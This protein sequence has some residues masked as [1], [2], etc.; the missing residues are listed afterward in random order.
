VGK[1]RIKVM[2]CGFGRRGGV[3]VFEKRRKILFL[4][5]AIFFLNSLAKPAYSWGFWGHR[6][7]NNNAVFLLPPPLFGFY[8]QH[9][10]YL[11]AHAADADMR[12][13][14]IKE[15]APRHYIDLDQYQ[16]TGSAKI[17]VQWKD[18]VNQYS[19]D[20][21]QLH[22]IVPWWIMVMHE[23]LK[24]AFAEKDVEQILKLSADIGHYIADAHVPLHASSNHNGQ[25]TDQLGIHAFWE[26]RLP[27]LFAEKQYDLFIG[28]AAYLK[29]P[30]HFIWDRVYESGA[31]AD[32]VL[33]IEKELSRQSA[34]HEKMSFEYRNDRLVRQYSEKYAARYHKQLNGMVERRMRSSVYAVASFWYTAW[35]DAGQPNLP[36]NTPSN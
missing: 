12:R 28:R 26:S 6:F 18:A 4:S 32:T 16:K 5:C 25:K 14:S 17:P 1:K 21:L 2:V 11:T 23:R 35:V 20:S 13:Y 15:E 34:D 24:N 7:I 10:I 29:E 31:A 33:K 27:E 9:I 22:G 19:V 3:W 36:F 30:L 8:K